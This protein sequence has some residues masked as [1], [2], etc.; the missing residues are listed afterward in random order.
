MLSKAAQ[1]AVRAAAGS[2]TR[3]GDWASSGPPPHAGSAVP[4]GAARRPA[5][6]Q[7]SR[8][9]TARAT[10]LEG[11]ARAWGDDYVRASR[12]TGSAPRDQPVRRCSPRGWEGTYAW[13]M[14]SLEGGTRVGHA[15]P[16]VGVGH[17][18]GLER[19]GEGRGGQLIAAAG[20]VGRARR[21]HVRDNA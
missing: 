13:A 20:G 19:H 16:L 9:A 18:V 4:A 1:L 2:S 8:P 21:P 6:V 14:P 3:G 17:P 15:E 12:A 7:E 11:G 10:A 5:E